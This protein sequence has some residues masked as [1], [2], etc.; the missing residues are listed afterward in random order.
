[1]PLFGGDFGREVATA[2]ADAT[3]LIHDIWVPST[4]RDRVAAVRDRVAGWSGIAALQEAG[5]TV[6]IACD[7][8]TANFP[9]GLI[10]VQFTPPLEGYN[11]KLL[12]AL[13][14]W[15]VGVEATSGPNLADY[16]LA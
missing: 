1:M 6:Q 14:A 9:L 10:G 8:P 16:R 3:S 15:A 7:L 4:D 12:P 13:S 2:Q 5:T 11:S